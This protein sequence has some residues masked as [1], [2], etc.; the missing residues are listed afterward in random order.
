MVQVHLN[1]FE[2][3]MQKLLYSFHFP[4]LAGVIV[5]DSIW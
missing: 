4:I 5:Y 1:K 2:E 3:N